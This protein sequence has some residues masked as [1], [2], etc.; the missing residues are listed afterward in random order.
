MT[1]WAEPPFE[2]GRPDNPW[3]LGEVT[4]FLDQYGEQDA[5]N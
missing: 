3:T 4:A 2:K 5:S 1:N